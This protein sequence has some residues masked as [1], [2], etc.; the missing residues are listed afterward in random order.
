MS[1][2]ARPAGGAEVRTPGPDVAP[3]EPLLRVRD[4]RVTFPPRRGH[5]A[6]TAVDG[7]SFD[8]WPG[9]TLGLVGESGSGKTTTGRAV[10]QLQ[11]VQAGS[12][13]LLGRELTG[14]TGRRLREMRRHMQFVL[15]NPYSSLHPRMTVERILAEPLQV[16][17][18]VPAHQVGA[19]VEEL[20]TLVGL[21]PA[22]RRRYPHEFSGGQ[23][24][25][26]VIARAL[27]VDPDFVVCDEPV[28]ALD[29]R[30]Q[31]QIVDL[32]MSLQQ[33][34]GVSY[35]FIAH[36]LAVVRQIADRVAVMFSGQ[37]VELG[38]AADVYSAP[39]H[40]YT[41]M[42]LAAVPVPDPVEQRRRL[43]AVPEV[44]DFRGRPPDG[45][46]VFGTDHA[47]AGDAAWH[48]IGPG[49]GVSCR[50]WPPGVEPDRTP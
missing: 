30:I 18:T 23:R 20:L 7:V 24:Q 35:L 8:I 48:E 27:A 31:A 21:D 4:L 13:S 39:A 16:H 3:S 43:A 47:A 5:P 22:V 6:I 36:D 15:Q 25:R 34:L 11:P 29:V 46:C 2:P 14:M 44:P 32:L 49:H 50:F 45:P 19:R 42:L 28:S 41:R 40:P 26:I 17:H 1:A 12:V 33:R 10:L 9:T 38:A 37:I